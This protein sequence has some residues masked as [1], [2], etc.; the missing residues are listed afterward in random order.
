MKLVGILLAF[1]GW[2]VPVLALTQTQSLAA[3]FVVAVVGI[4]ISLVGIL[5][6]LNGAHLKEAIW[7]R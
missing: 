4:I 5:V 6:V 1:I 2:V 7:K 3:R